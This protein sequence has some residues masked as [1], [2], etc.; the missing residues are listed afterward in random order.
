MCCVVGYIG[1]QQSRSLVLEGLTRLEYRGYDSA[2]F[3]CLNAE[4]NQISAVKAIGG[5]DRLTQQCVVTPVDGFLGLGHTR[6]STHGVPNLENAHPVMDC[7]DKVAV[8]HN[9]I[10]ENYAEI[11]DQLTQQGHTFVTKT[12][13]E[14]IAHLLEHELAT[15]SLHRA[16]ESTVGQLEGAYAFAALISARSDMLLAVRLRSPL[17]IGIG[18]D[19]MFVASDQLAFAGKAQK[20]LFLPDASYACVYQ[21]HIELYDFQGN[22]LAIDPQPLTIVWSESGKQGYEHYMLKE[23]YEQKRV[24]AATVSAMRSFQRT[25]EVQL[26]VTID[27]LREVEH[28]VLIGCGTSWHAAHIAKFYFES[29][30]KIPVTVGLASEFK[31]REF[32]IPQKSLCIAISQSGE[33]ADTL[34]VVRLLQE[35]SFPIIALTN[36][37]SS[38]LVRE[39]LGLLLT[40]AGQEIAVASTKSFSAQIA[41]LF[42]FSHLIALHKGYL[43]QAEVEFAHEE[44][45]VAAEVMEKSIE[46]YKNIINDEIAPWCATHTQAI[47]LGRHMSYTLAQEA[48]LKLKEIAYIFA[49]AFPAGELKHGPIALIDKKALVFLFSTLDPIVYQKLVSNAQEVKSRGGQIIVFAFEGQRELIDLADRAFIF[50]TVHPLLAPLAMLGVM[51]YLVYKIAHVLHLP[52]DK[53]RNLAKSVTVE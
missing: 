8:V 9:G 2:G 23:I 38:S 21:D 22:K 1:R 6:W 10:I 36:V 7:H 50:S 49:E 48:A 18:E 53:P 51:Q 31:H 37:A 39:S 20:V 12:D 5:V 33:T 11:R 46:I 28:I 41:S 17:C 25:L 15:K 3:A 52:I 34:E 24:M 32:F 42:L 19:G 14:V 45:L 29:L 13:T 44:L 30:C 40:H 35:R 43:K 16:V 4:T 47:F 27:Y 26:G